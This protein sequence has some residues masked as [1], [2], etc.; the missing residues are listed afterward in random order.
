MKKLT[1]RFT[2]NNNYSIPCIGYGTWQVSD[3]DAAIEAIHKAVKNGY[4]HID[5]A[6]FYGNEVGIGSAIKSCGVPREELFITS[7]VWKT[8][9][10]YEKTCQAFEQTMK[11]LGLAYLDLYLIH[12]PNVQGTKEEW[13]KMNQS[14]WRALEKF[15]EEG[16]IKAIGVSNFKPHHLESLMKEATIKPMVNQIEFHP[17]FMQQETLEY[18]KKNNILVEAWSPLGKGRVLQDPTL[19]AIAAKYHKS[20]AQLC[21]RWC[22]QNGVLPLPKSV[23]E[24]RIIENSN[25]FDFELSTEEMQVINGM[26]IFGESGEDPDCQA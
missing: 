8:D 18:C 1:D 26:P 13:E 10:G 11:N 17:G 5:T 25:V 21:V 7:K 24:A 12:W 16:R 14:T 6:A 20:T 3:G 23:T 2:L 4:R 19:Q 15:Y 9:C 22:L